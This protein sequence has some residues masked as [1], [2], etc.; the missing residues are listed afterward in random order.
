MLARFLLFIC[1]LGNLYGEKLLIPMDLSQ[2]DHLRAYGIAFRAVST[3]NNVE[4]LLNFRG[5][6]FLMDYGAAVE[7]DCAM[8]GVRWEL[9]SISD[10]LSIYQTIEENNMETILLEKAPRIA[11]YI[12]D[13]FEPWDDAVTLALEYAGV[14][15]DQIWDD[16]VLAG[17]LQ[18]YDWLHLHHEDF[19]GQ[20]GKF[21]GSQRQNEW[22]QSEV[23]MNEDA[24]RRLGFAKVSKLKLSVGVAIKEYIA[25][26]GFV[27]SMCSA[28]D[29]YE[30]ALAAAGVDIC[31]DVF[32][33]DPH[34]SQANS[35]LDF[36]RCLAFEN[37]Q[38]IV[39][40]LVYE[41]STIDVTQEA[42]RRGSEHVLLAV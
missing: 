1:L 10:V 23:R 24:A 33:G 29:T 14:P 26:G 4:W 42:S 27:F 20:Y 13:N 2:T 21:Y 3:G 18:K 5:G 17:I 12:P 37:F 22:Y 19:T 31:H 38:V 7:R 32:D 25:Q 41:H 11:V 35:M 28:C 34:N 36:S 30:I 16:E 39:D 9:V 8:N 40:P 15:Y 6:S